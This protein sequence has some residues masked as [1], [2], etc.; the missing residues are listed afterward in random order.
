MNKTVILALITLFAAGCSA[1]QGVLSKNPKKEKFVNFF[2]KDKFVFVEVREENEGQG[3]RHFGPAVNPRLTMEECIPPAYGYRLYNN[4]NKL[5]T[6]EFGKRRGGSAFWIEEF[7][8]PEIG[9]TIAIIGYTLQLYSSEGGVTGTREITFIETLP[10][11]LRL[12]ETSEEYFARAHKIH[13]NWTEGP[14]EP[15]VR[16][17][18][19][20]LLDLEKDGTIVIRCE[21]KEIS[22]EPGEFWHDSRKVKAGFLKSKS[23]EISI[24]VENHGV[25]DKNN[26]VKFIESKLQPLR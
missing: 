22:L 26:D 20:T 7:P 8:K 10:S 25:F 24:R 19:I 23:I 17:S 4:D 11:L 15:L 21:D 9:N 18:P 1:E 3:I 13:T 2:P 16:C 12:S 14:S 5:L 6:I